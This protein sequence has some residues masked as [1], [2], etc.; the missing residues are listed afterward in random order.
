VRSCGLRTT[1]GGSTV[2]FGSLR[3]AIRK[4]TSVG[5]CAAEAGFNAIEQNLDF[6]TTLDNW[7]S[8]GD[9]RFFKVIVSPEF[10]DRLNFQQHTRELMP[11]NY[12]LGI[13]QVEF[14]FTESNRHRF[15]DFYFG[16][17][18]CG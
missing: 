9:E 11:R 17:V 1:N 8:A 15:E 4:P 14:R 7:Q 10:G 18:L 12:S 2:A 5:G 16:F 13:I 3:S 6:S